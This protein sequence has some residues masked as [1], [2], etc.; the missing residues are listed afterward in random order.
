M[1]PG[2]TIHCGLILVLALG[3]GLASGCDK[4]KKKKDKKFYDNPGYE[5]PERRKGDRVYH[6]SENQCKLNRA[7]E[8]PKAGTAEAAI[9]GLFIAGRDAAKAKDPAGKEQAFVAFFGHLKG[10]GIC[11]KSGSER[12]LRRD[13]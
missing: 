6:E 4:D 7:V 2:L 13:F 8:S 10:G 9:Q 5:L 1:R 11:R 12:R 3:V